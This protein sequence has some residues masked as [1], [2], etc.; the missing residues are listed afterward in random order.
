MLE[1]GPKRLSL[2]QQ[3]V[4]APSGPNVGA[5]FFE[6]PLERDQRG[7]VDAG[8]QRVALSQI[9]FVIRRPNTIGAGTATTIDIIAIAKPGAGYVLQ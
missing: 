2:P 4:V 3:E 9:E 5:G 8:Q 7:I 6:L 1:G